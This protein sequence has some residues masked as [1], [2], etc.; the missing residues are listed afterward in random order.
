MDMAFNRSQ[1]NQQRRNDEPLT[2][3]GG[4]YDS[5]SGKA[6]TGNVRV[7]EAR[8]GDAMPLGEV[9]IDIIRR[10]M[11]ERRT[12]RFLV[13]QND[14]KFRNSPPYTLHATIGDI[15]KE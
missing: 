15:A 4:L 2:R 13:F 6:I 3:L 11:D 14:G 10:A 8:K 5:K 7:H 12:L 1:Q 9:L